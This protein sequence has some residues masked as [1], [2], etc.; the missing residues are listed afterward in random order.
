MYE[1][2]RSDAGRQAQTH[3]PI[4]LRPRDRT[5]ATGR[6]TGGER[7]RLPS[8]PDTGEHVPRHSDD[9]SFGDSPNCW[10]GA[11]VGI[12]TACSSG[13]PGIAC[14]VLD[15]CPPIATTTARFRRA[16][17]LGQVLWDRHPA[18]ACD[19]QGRPTWPGS[20]AAQREAGV[21][22]C[23]AAFRQVKPGRHGRRLSSPPAS[24]GEP[25]PGVRVSECG[26]FLR[27]FPGG[28]TARRSVRY[29]RISAPRCFPEKHAQRGLRSGS[30]A[31]WA[32]GVS[33]VRPR[34]RT[35]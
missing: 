4:W 28:L 18:L 12:V 3:R 14:R 23:I 33:D 13:L 26:D 21:C 30:A 9:F 7:L 24:H 35:A 5:I 25:R 11:A 6:G 16:G 20:A 31:T 8:D 27:A 29:G 34:G 15:Q 22:K 2:Q 32:S 1:R 10:C 19:Q 17:A